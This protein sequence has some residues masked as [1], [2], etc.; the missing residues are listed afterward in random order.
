MYT[1]SNCAPYAPYQIIK[2]YLSFY[3]KVAMIGISI[4]VLASAGFSF[5]FLVLGCYEICTLHCL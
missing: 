2:C 3:S 4:I 5:C 1:Q